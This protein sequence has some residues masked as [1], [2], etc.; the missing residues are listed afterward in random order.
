MSTVTTSGLDTAKSVFQ[1][2]DISATGEVLI[3][4]QVRRGQ[5]LKF[6]AHSAT[7]SDRH[8]GVCLSPSL[9]P[10]AESAWGMR[11]A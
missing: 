4:R 2:H 1:V 11:C 5:V 8:R 9:G 7:R 10:R 6:F 3:R